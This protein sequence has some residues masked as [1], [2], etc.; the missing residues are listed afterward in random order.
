MGAVRGAG[1]EGGGEPELGDGGFLALLVHRGHLPTD[2]AAELARRAAAGAALDTLLAAEPG[3][4]KDRVAELRRT[5]A[6]ERPDVPGYD[7]LDRVGRGG[8]ADVWAARERRTG[9]DVA[10]K[11]LRPEAALHAPTLRAFVREGKLLERLDHPGLVKGLGVA[12][13]GD[14]YLSRLELL[15]GETALEILERGERMGEESALAIV[16]DVAEVLAYL[17]VEGLVH[18]DVKPGNIVRTRSGR[19]VLIDLGFAADQGAVDRGA[20]S[21]VGTAAYLSPE[22]A[23]GGAAADARSDVYSLGVSLF[24]LVV[25]RLPFEASKTEDLLR[26][27]IER[28]LSSP[29]LRRRGISPHLHYFVE[30]M[31]AKDADQRFQSFG[32]LIAQVR[33]ALDGRRGLDFG[34]GP[35]SNPP[36]RRPRR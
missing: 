22:Q 28:E 21:A 20:D 24:Q 36:P 30:K 10:L 2:R 1:R 4:T 3:W 15:D 14:L 5:R 7:L 6:G 18:R 31:T 27:H 9:R 23:R 32:E 33:G 19:T 29:E 12:R 8:T 35:R 34:S 25:G 16:L 11:L 26:Q 13:S 17:E